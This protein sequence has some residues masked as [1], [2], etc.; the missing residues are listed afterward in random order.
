MSLQSQRMSISWKF[1]PT[2]LKWVTALEESLKNASVL[3]GKFGPTMRTSNYASGWVLW[4]PLMPPELRTSSSLWELLF[5]R[6]G[7]IM[8]ITA[9]HILRNKYS[10]P[11]LSA[12]GTLTMLLSSCLSPNCVSCAYELCSFSWF[13]FVGKW[14]RVSKEERQKHWKHFESVLGTINHFYTT[15]KTNQDDVQ[16]HKPLYSPARDHLLLLVSVHCSLLVSDSLQQ[17]NWYSWSQV[18]FP[19]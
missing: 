9:S 14:G 3:H 18:K 6:V 16:I 10:V 2:C 7:Q 12:T 13:G 5:L 11:N 15:S 1:L 4:N 19:M 17:G 8:G